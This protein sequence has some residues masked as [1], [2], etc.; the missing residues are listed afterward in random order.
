MWIITL[1][2]VVET[3]DKNVPRP[4]DVYIA[5][6]SEDVLLQYDIAVFSE[7]KDLC[8]NVT[9]H[10]NLPSLN[11]WYSASDC[12]SFLRSSSYYNHIITTN[13]I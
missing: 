12:S 6:R 3:R 1:I 2:S 13:N 10:V 11:F 4:R 9:E 7:Y 5:I 8:D